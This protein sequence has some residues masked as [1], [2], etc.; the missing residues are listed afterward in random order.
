MNR[1]F[2]S[3]NGN[4]IIKRL[5]TVFASSKFV[6]ELEDKMKRDK[7]DINLLMSLKI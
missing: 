3:E 1:S 5:V 2:I 6:D 7:I 4:M